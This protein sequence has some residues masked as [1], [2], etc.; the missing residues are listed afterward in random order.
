[1]RQIDGTKLKKWT[2]SRY[3]VTP[4][5]QRATSIKKKGLLIVSFQPAAVDKTRRTQEGVQSR[6]K[7][8][9]MHEHIAHRFQIGIQEGH[10]GEKLRFRYKVGSGKN[11]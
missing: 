4:W 1:M 11:L 6:A 9:H 8:V 2:L 10:Q 5:V 3:C 7:S